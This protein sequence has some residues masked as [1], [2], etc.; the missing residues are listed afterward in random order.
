MGIPKNSPEI[1]QA[2][3]VLPNEKISHAIRRFV[4]TELAMEEEFS[5][6]SHL[7]K[8]I[9]RKIY[10]EN[11]NSFVKA[12]IYASRVHEAIQKLAKEGDI[13]VEKEK[14]KIDEKGQPIRPVRITPRGLFKI[15]AEEE[16]W[17]FIEK[18]APKQEDKFPL[19]G[20][21]EYFNER[22]V[23]DTFIAAMKHFF[24]Y[25][26][27]YSS[28]ELSKMGEEMRENMLKFYDSTI[29]F[30]LAHHVLFLPLLLPS[31]PD[32]ALKWLRVWNEKPHLKS[33][34]MEEFQREKERSNEINRFLEYLK[35]VETPK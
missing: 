32:D 4:L 3:I 26:L 35:N 16:T 12:T 5:W 30:N 21:W 10:K 11:N 15:L 19:F 13:L 23:K 31:H 14:R 29:P 17:K 8:E 25:P 6:Y 9:S 24:Q 1:S 18:I 7:Y 22:K 2:H 28:K 20:Y 33:F 34:M 27:P